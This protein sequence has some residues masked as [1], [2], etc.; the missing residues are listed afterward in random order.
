MQTRNVRG[1][2]GAFPENRESRLLFKGSRAK[3]QARR[4]ATVV[5][6]LGECWVGRE[7]GGGGEG[8]FCAPLCLRGTSDKQAAGLIL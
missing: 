2:L 1:G 3:E 8:Y 6:F 5:G 4:D 7:E